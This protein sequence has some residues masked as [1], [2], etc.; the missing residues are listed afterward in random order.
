MLQSLLFFREWS[1]TGKLSNHDETDKQH[2]NVD[3]VIDYVMSYC[4]QLMFLG[5]VLPRAARTHCFGKP[6]H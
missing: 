5:V 2:L 3:F 4:C 6:A 1:E